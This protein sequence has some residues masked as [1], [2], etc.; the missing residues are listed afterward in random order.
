MGPV[1]DFLDLVIFQVCGLQFYS[2]IRTW[3]PS[4]KLALKAPENGWLG[5][6]PF[7]LG[8]SAYFQGRTVSFREGG[9]TP[10]QGFQSPPG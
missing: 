6:D 1:G 10:H 4:L 5:D 7:I 8:P 3:K 9:C 2:H